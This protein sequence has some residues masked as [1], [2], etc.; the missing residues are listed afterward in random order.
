MI[1]LGNENVDAVDSNGLL[2]GERERKM[3]SDQFVGWKIKY[4]LLRS[5]K[6][7]DALLILCSTKRLRSFKLVRWFAILNSHDPILRL[8]KCKGN[9]KLLVLLV[10]LTFDLL[11]AFILN[12]QFKYNFWQ[13]KLSL[14]Q[15]NTSILFFVFLTGDGPCLGTRD[16]I[17]KKYTWLTYNQVNVGSK[18]IK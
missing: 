12:Y 13:Q 10:V 18:I 17:S 11:T 6:K 15:S 14:V 9:Y 1:S 4:L 3:I 2:H 16:P 5:D 8:S 7:R